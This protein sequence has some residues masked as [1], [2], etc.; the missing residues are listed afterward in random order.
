MQDFEGFKISVEEVTICRLVQI[1]SEIELEMEPEEV[2]ELLQ[3]QDKPLKTEYFFLS[4]STESCFERESTPSVAAMNTVET[5]KKCLVAGGCERI[6][7]ILN[8]VPCTEYIITCYR[9]KI[10]ESQCD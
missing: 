10:H 6:D 3:S 8:E 1:A 2:T 7:F 5:I 4:R 9:E